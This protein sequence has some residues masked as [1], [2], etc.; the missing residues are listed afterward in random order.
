LKLAH[1]SFHFSFSAFLEYVDCIDSLTKVQVC[2]DPDDDKF[3]ACA[4]D[5]GSDCI[6]SG[7]KDLLDLQN[8]QGISIVTARRFFDAIHGLTLPRTNNQ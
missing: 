8:Y 6:I 2:R 7:D 1:K 3:L 5:S 4:V